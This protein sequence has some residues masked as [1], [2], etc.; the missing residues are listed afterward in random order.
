MITI[1][2]ICKNNAR[3]L[4]ETLESLFSQENQHWNAVIV[5]GE[6]KDGS[7]EIAKVAGKDS[8]VR[9]V[10]QT[11]SGIYSAM[12]LGIAAADKKAKY[13]WFMNSGDCFYANDSLEIVHQ[14]IVEKKFDL[15]IGNY[16][17]RDHSQSIT[18]VKSRIK[19]CGITRFAF[20]IHSACHQSMI[21]N[22]Q[23]L[24]E[25]GSYDINY[26]YA[27]DFDLALKVFRNKN[28]R[29]TEF[30]LSIIEGRGLSDS[31]IIK[32]HLEKHQIRKQHFS[33]IWV[34]G[35]NLAWTTVVILY[36]SLKSLVWRLKGFIC[37]VEIEKTRLSE[38]SLDSRK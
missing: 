30:I 3:G 35:L 29:R 10:E 9:I 37:K 18:V 5:V 14:E 38:V 19:N 11:D 6:S 15:L 12:N 34:K 17:F 4:R 36:L 2:T 31:N 32:V 25:N 24:L 1:I 23:S 27:S 16:S 8:R 13:L 21:F 7:L 22:A 28:V 20:S 26:I 33:N